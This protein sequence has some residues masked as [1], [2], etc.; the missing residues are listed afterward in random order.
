[1]P[2]QVSFRASQQASATSA[3]AGVYTAGGAN[4]TECSIIRM[5]PDGSDV[6]TYAFGVRNSVGADLFFAHNCYVVT[7]QPYSSTRCLL[8]VVTAVRITS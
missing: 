8:G 6:S 2:C 4:I 7:L 3:C 1:M 5:L